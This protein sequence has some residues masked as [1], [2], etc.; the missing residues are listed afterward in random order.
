MLI[1]L[2][3]RVGNLSCCISSLLGGLSFPFRCFGLGRASLAVGRN[4][5]DF[6]RSA[7]RLRCRS[8]SL[9]QDSH[10]HVDG[11]LGTTLLQ[12]RH[13]A[14]LVDDDHAPTRAFG[15]F[16]HADG[17]DQLPGRI[18]EKRVWERLFGSK[19]GVGFGRVGAEAVDR[20]TGPSE[21]GII[22]PEEAG[23][24]RA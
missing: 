10:H 18:A 2:C 17:S 3:G 15:W 5:S 22:V 16:L 7:G 23:L 20:K 8:T 21:M 9:G 4:L 13:F 1:E 6:G 14:G 11:P 24:C 19:G 12:G